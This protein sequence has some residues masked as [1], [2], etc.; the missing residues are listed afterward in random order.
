MA[1]LAFRQTDT[2]ERS[3]AARLLRD[4]VAPLLGMSMFWPMLRYASFVRVLF[5]PEATVGLAGATLTAHA[6]FLCLLVAVTAGAY[7][8]R[9]PLASLMAQRKPACAGAMAMGAP[10]AAL[11][12]CVREGVAPAQLLWLAG[13]LAAIGV[14]AC[15]LCWARKLSQTPT[16]R[17]VCMVVASFL[18]SY[19]CFSYSVPL[20]S[21]WGSAAGSIVTPLGTALLWLVSGPAGEGATSKLEGAPR[22]GGPSLDQARPLLLAIGSGLVVGAAVRG[23]VDLTA[24]I[25]SVRLATSLAINA[26][27]LAAVVGLCVVR[28]R[29][30]RADAARRDFVE[31]FSLI[32]WAGFA[33]VFLAGLFVFLALGQTRLGGDLVVASRTAMSVAL[34]MLLCS[35]A[36]S[37]DAANRVRLFLRHGFAIE[38]ASWLLSY[39]VIPGAIGPGAQ[40]TLTP[41]GF[42]L[43]VIFGVA[44]LLLAGF[45]LR[46][47]FSHGGMD[48]GETPGEPAQE[49]M[50]GTNPNS[51]EAGGSEA[52]STAADKIDRLVTEGLLTPREA[53]VVALYSQGLSL[54]KVAE[55]LC[56]TKSTAQSHIKN[57]YRK[58]DVH[59]RDELIERLRP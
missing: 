57:A 42:V 13:L 52:R 48:M 7:L 56:I 58:L 45:A 19:A 44:A 11:A 12:L 34:L 4:V 54:G 9:G 25:S 47:A 55:E 51:G 39:V 10:G 40:G 16:P 3:R 49:C 1:E 2:A 35:L 46:L 17:A 6:A 27:W 20:G 15:Y 41:Q 29:G 36:P 18:L 21:L 32:S 26:A 59:S 22:T 5:P 37:L 50:Q 33:L 24:P 38:V 14:L 43:A 28:S 53:A 23:I 30:G 8:L 31:R